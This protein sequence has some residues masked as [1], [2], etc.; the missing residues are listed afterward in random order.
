[1]NPFSPVHLAGVND[2]KDQNEGVETNV[3]TVQNNTL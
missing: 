1:M 3:T 2:A